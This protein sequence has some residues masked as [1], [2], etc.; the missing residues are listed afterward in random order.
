MMP[1]VPIVAV[2][3]LLLGADDPAKSELDRYHGT[4]VLVSEEFEGTKVPAKDL[5]DEL[6]NLSYTVRGE[7]LLYTSRGEARWATIK[8]D[9]NKSPK[10]YDLVRD[11]GRPYKG[12]YAWDGDKIKICA[13]GDGGDRPTAFETKPG[14]KN[15]IRVWQ[16]RR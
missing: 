2:A 3:G 10:T 13:A 5:A 1:I 11:D 14:S 12:I 15:R 9:P 4:W 8:L 16:R 6:Q 7:K